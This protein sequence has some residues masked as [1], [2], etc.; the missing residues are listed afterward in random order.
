MKLREVGRAATCL[1]AVL[2][3]LSLVAC[4]SA[5]RDDGSGASTSN[6]SGDSWYFNGSYWEGNGGAPYYRGGVDR[7]APQGMGTEQSRR[8]YSNGR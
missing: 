1:A 3:M 8:Y 5:P 4:N 6:G 2:V 7:C